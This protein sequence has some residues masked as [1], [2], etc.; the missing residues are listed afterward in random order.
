MKKTDKKTVNTKESILETALSLFAQFG[1]EAVSTQQIAMSLNITKGALYKHYESKQAIFDSILDRMEKTDALSALDFNMPM[2]DEGPRNA[3]IED[4]IAYSRAM[5]SYWTRDVFASRFRRMLTIEQYK[6]ERMQSL[7]RQYL[8]SGPMEY[9]KSILQRMGL[10]SAKTLAVEFYAPMFLLYD[11]E[12]IG[13]AEALL[14]S[15]FKEI[16]TKV[17]DELHNKT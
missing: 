17:K 11:L 13:N 15:H 14:D 3:T 9:V 1:Y 4:L 5:F 16:E 2:D 6:S 7:M 12:D 10:A 8:T